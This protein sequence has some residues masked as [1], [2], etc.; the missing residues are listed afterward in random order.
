MRSLRSLCFT[1]S[2]CLHRCACLFAG[3]QKAACR[4]ASRQN[5]GIWR[6]RSWHGPV[7]VLARSCQRSCQR[8]CHGFC[9]IFGGFDVDVENIGYD[10]LIGW[11]GEAIRCYKNHDRTVDRTADRPEPGPCQDR[12]R[13]VGGRDGDES[14]DFNT[15]ASSLHRNK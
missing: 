7:T 8:S 6:R 2:I 15:R 13:T 12:D 10:I 14:V 1:C 4:Q 3:W 9:S 11:C 5:H